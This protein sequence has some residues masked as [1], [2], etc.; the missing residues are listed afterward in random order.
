MINS[1][2]KTHSKKQQLMT[3]DDLVTLHHQMMLCYGWISIDEFKDIPL[4]TLLQIKKLVY[5][6]LEKRETLRL[7][8]LK[9]YGVKNPK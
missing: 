2:L 9:Y 5:E 7:T 4:P 3:E 1:P 6:E 8:T